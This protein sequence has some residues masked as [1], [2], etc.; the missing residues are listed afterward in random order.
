MGNGAEIR[1]SVEIEDFGEDGGLMAALRH[2]I[3]YRF[4]PGELEE[5]EEGEEAFS[6]DAYQWTIYGREDENPQRIPAELRAR[7]HHEYLGALR[8]VEGDLRSWW[9]SPLRNLLE[10]A[11]RDAV[12]RSSP[13]VRPSSRRQPSEP[14]EKD[15]ATPS[16][17]RSHRNIPRDCR[18]RLR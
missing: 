12:Q 5:L 11:A 6:P 3:T 17:D 15:H 4:G 10:Q 16:T 18:C 9:R 8:D 7:L 13:L 2:T 1:I 14:K